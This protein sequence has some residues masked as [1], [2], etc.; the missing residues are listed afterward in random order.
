MDLCNFLLFYKENNQTKG[1]KAFVRSGIR[2]HASIRR[3]E[4]P[5]PLCSGKV[6]DLESGALDRSAIL[7]TVCSD[8]NILSDYSMPMY[9]FL[10]YKF[11]KK[12]RE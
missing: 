9:A 10:I 3:P 12:T 2:T 8:Y 4:R 1:K 7:T 6:F 11:E 5:L